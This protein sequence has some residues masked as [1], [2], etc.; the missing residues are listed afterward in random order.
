MNSFSGEG[1]ISH[2]KFYSVHL[3]A[4]VLQFIYYLQFIF[5]DVFTYNFSQCR[6]YF[7]IIL[8]NLS[9]G[10]C[11]SSYYSPKFAFLI[12]EEFTLDERDSPEFRRIHEEYKHLVY[13][14][15]DQF[16]CKHLFYFCEFI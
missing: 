8:F 5:L 3:R 16:M 2:L 7:L 4:M 15:F 10:I 6:F 13:N 12:I 14:N 11:L 9:F 1:I